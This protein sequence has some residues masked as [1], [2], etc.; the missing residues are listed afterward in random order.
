[1]IRINRC[2]ILVLLAGICCA[3]ADTSV[4]AGY[5]VDVHVEN[6]MGNPIDDA[7]V[8]L[9]PHMTVYDISDNSGDA[10]LDSDFSTNYMLVVRHQLYGR[11]SPVYFDLTEDTNF[12]VVLPPLT[13]VRIASY[14]MEGNRN[15]GEWDDE[16]ILPLARIFWTVQPDIVLLQECPENG[17]LFSDFAGQYLPGYESAEST[18]GYYIHNG[19]CSFYPIEESFSEGGS[20]MTRDLFGARI[21][22]NQET[23]YTCL[24]AHYKAGSSTSDREKRNGEAQFTGEYCSNLHASS[25]SYIF[26]GDLNDDPGYPRPPSVI[27]DILYNSGAQLVRLDPQDDNGST[28]TIPVI[29]RRYDYLMPVSTVADDVLH[30]A[31][32]RTE[33]LQTLPAWLDRGDSEMASDHRMIYADIAVAPEPGT[34][35]VIIMVMAGAMVVNKR[36]I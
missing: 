34:G 29:P 32:F 18:E 16:Q 24:S 7:Y 19:I 35:I 14:N 23:A 4:T 30:T 28:V 13:Y 17:Y 25:V 33:T 1:M 8:W 10:T 20:V 36:R 2:I 9:G 22:I 26:G 31:V 15:S 6:S 11:V 27:F 12:T 3:F 21:T 5:S